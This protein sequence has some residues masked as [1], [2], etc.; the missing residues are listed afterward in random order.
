[1]GTPPRLVGPALGIGIFLA[2][3]VFAWWTLRS[4][5]SVVARLVAFG[6]LSFAVLAQFLPSPQSTASTVVPSA[7]AQPAQPSALAAEPKVDENYLIRCV[8][9]E[10][11]LK[12]LTAEQREI[13]GQTARAE[14]AAAAAVPKDANERKAYFRSLRERTQEFITIGRNMD[15]LR[16]A[17]SIGACAREMRTYQP[18]AH[19]LRMRVP[20]RSADEDSIRLRGA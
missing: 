3:P 14:A 13:C 17:S 16:N 9:I 7:A 12:T 8:G 20:A 15:E 2:P 19:E 11:S 10:V 1:V 4:G 6:W 5:H 18:Q